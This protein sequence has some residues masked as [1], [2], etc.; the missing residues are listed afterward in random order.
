[1]AKIARARTKQ[2]DNPFP[3]KTC[4][5]CTHS[6]DWNNRSFHDGHLILCR[7]P[8][9]EKSRHGQFCKLLSDAACKMFKQR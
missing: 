9:D 8:H 6:Y 7:C 2:P 1:M 4:R 5:D 3:D